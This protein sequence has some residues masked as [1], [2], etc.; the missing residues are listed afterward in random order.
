MHLVIGR[1]NVKAM[2]IRGANLTQG[3]MFE[4]PGGI[5]QRFPLV[6]PFFPQLVVTDLGQVKFN[7][8]LF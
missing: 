2:A 8:S 1:L 3:T 4:V 6:T 5:Q 7:R